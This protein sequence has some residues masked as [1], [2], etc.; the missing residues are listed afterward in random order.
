MNNYSYSHISVFVI[1]FITAG[2]IYCLYK[3]MLGSGKKE[4]DNELQITSTE[5][6]EQLTILHREKRY[7]IVE[8]LAKNYLEKKGGNDDVRTIL[9]KSLFDMGKIYDA[10][11]QAKIIIRHQPI[12]FKIKIFLANCYLKVEKPFKAIDTFQEILEEDSDNILAIKELAQAYFD[13]NQKRSAIKMYKRLEEFLENN[14]EKV[15]N[16]STIAKIHIEFGEYNLAIE[17]YEKAL[18]IYPDDISIKKRLIELYKKISDYDSSIGFASELYTTCAEDE[19][20]L[21]ALKML[22]DIYQI[23]QN[24]EKALEYANLIK[25]HPLS[26]NIQSDEDIARI[27]LDEGKVYE[28]IELLKSLVDENPEN[29]KLKKQLAKAYE[30]N[31]DFKSA[32][33]IYTKILDEANAR[34]INDIHFELS[35]IYSNWA[36]YSFSLHENDDC[37][38]HFTVALKYH[39]QNPEIYYLL[40]TVN[41]TIKNFNE[42]ISQYKKAIELDPQNPCYYCA[43]AECYEELDNIY[44]QKKALSECLKHDSENAKTHYKLSIIYNIQNDKNN[45]MIH[46]KK[47]IELD[48]N[49]IEAKHKLAL[50]LEHTGDT[51]GA[52]SVYEDILKIDPENEEILNN[53]RMLSQ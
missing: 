14:N 52:I 53:L 16:K 9:A 39:S 21:W 13:T 18:E 46:I 20:G 38:K 48:E 35:N 49:F 28:S 42:A 40:G 33:N 50:M 4:Q 34:D 25:F 32:V 29:T 41:Q 37:F 12:N 8:S 30:R 27:L 31:K 11:D 45:A 2:L 7:N 10:I 6:L 17:E 3:I 26:D 51:E 5:L 22:M 47:A 19:N 15:K 24:Y 43:I 44:E 1:I 36:M 23:M